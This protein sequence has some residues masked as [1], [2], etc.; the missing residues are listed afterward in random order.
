MKWIICYSIVIAAV[1][2]VGTAQSEIED[3]SYNRYG[4]DVD[5]PG[6]SC[7]DVY[8]NNPYSR[9]KS[10]YY[11]IKTNDLFLAQCDMETEHEGKKKG[12]L[13]IA[14]FDLSKG[15]SCPEGWKKVKVS[16]IEMCR[17]LYDT[18]GCYSTSFSVNG[19]KYRKIR[20]MVRGYQKG[21]TDGFDS[22]YGGDKGINTAYVDGVSITLGYPRKHVWTYVV[23]ISDDHNYPTSNCPCAAVPGPAPYSFV[24]ENYY[25]ESGNNGTYTLHTYYTNDQLWDGAGCFHD[26]N[27][28]CTDADLPWFYREFATSQHDNIEVRICTDQDY[29]DEAVLVDKLTLLIQ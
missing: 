21:S 19:T 6:S 3:N 18:A 2:L 26:N 13:K 14:D 28:C 9:G 17:S 5:Y 24:G 10:G 12:W 20:G 16:G 22:R 27:N 11:L 1:L 29:R 15:D 25:C 7:A 23:G 8:E 4:L